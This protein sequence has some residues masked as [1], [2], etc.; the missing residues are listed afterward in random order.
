MGMADH[1]EH[2]ECRHGS[3][4]SVVLEKSE[5]INSETFAH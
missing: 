4:C 5:A 1:E 2:P 3:S